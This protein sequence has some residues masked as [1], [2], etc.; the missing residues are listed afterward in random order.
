MQCGLLS[1]ALIVV[2]VVASRALQ[3]PLQLHQTTNT[4]RD[5][6]VCSKPRLSLVQLQS[7]RHFDFFIVYS[8]L[9][10]KVTPTLLL[11]TKRSLFQVMK[12]NPCTRDIEY[13]T[14]SN[15]LM[16]NQLSE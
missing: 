6:R 5:C 3:R 11:S 13:F 9:H 12:P 10:R 8:F 16:N 2:L 7:K 1:I 4:T 14:Q 15:P